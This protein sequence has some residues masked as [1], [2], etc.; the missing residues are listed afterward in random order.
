MEY[1]MPKDPVQVEQLKL[2]K[3]SLSVQEE[4]LK[5]M[6]KSLIL[7][8]GL[9]GVPQKTISAIIVCD[10]NLV[11]EVLKPIDLKKIKEKQGGS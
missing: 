6:R 2:I 9:L 8:L 1:T 11:S 5:L 10:I 7:Q 3:K 4:Q